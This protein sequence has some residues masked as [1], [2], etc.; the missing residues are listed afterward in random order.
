MPKLPGG[1]AAGSTAPVELAYRLGYFEDGGV[2]H[3]RPQGQRHNLAAGLLGTWQIALLQTA[4]AE[5]RVE[6]Q[7]HWIVN[8]GPHAALLQVAPELVAPVR[9]HHVQMTDRFG[10][11]KH[12]ANSRAMRK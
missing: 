4:I 5:C 7:G 12:Q 1:D 3:V 6:V 10:S 9:A 2:S 11:S 8:A